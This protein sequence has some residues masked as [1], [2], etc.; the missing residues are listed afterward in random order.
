MWKIS[1]LEFCLCRW[2]SASLYLG[3]RISQVIKNNER[4][5]TEGLSLAMVFC[6]ISANLTYGT[7]IFMRLYSWYVCCHP[8]LYIKRYLVNDDC[9][10]ECTC[11]YLWIEVI[12]FDVLLGPSLMLITCSWLPTVQARVRCQGTVVSGELRNRL[13]RHYLTSAGLY[14]QTITGCLVAMR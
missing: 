1:S 8:A 13:P 2:A 14:L 4:G 6:A 3:S 9:Q 10:N 12:G 5:S 11:R 7:S